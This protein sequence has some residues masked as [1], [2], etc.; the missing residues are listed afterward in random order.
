ML[1]VSMNPLFLWAP[2]KTVFA[3]LKPMYFV[4]AYKIQSIYTYTLNA[5]IF[6][7]HVYLY[8]YIYVDCTLFL[9]VIQDHISILGLRERCK[10][11]VFRRFTC[12]ASLFLAPVVRNDAFWNVL[13][14]L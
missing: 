14:P 10:V 2:V 7:L 12:K 11:A 1:E 6:I 4:Y 3:R 5:C 13:R 8:I 9:L